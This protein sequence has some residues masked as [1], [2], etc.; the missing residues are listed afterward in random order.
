MLDKEKVAINGI[1]ELN[2]DSVKMKITL[3]EYA[4]ME[5]QSDETLFQQKFLVNTLSMTESSRLKEPFKKVP[6]NCL[7]KQFLTLKA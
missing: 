3:N 7:Q 2:E 1:L 6:P 5:D 4:R